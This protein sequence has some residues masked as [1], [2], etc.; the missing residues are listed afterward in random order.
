MPTSVALSPHFEAFVKDQVSTGRFNN[1]SEVVRAGLRLLEDQEQLKALKLQEL[2]TAIQA[3]ASSG[4]GVDSE[5][6]F[7]RLKR[8]YQSAA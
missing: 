1:V 6:V 5:Q 3:G 7:E 2:H 4:P 8:K